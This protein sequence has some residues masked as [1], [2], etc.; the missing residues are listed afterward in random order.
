[1]V[2][3]LKGRRERSTAVVEKGGGPR[4][5]PVREGI[6]DN[7]GG[8]AFPMKGYRA[9]RR[10]GGGRVVLDRWAAEAGLAWAAGKK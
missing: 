6:D 5:R 4:S 1:L 8:D 3:G 2:W 9:G 10:R 7:K